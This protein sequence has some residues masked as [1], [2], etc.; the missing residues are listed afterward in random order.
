MLCAFLGIPPLAH[1]L[2]GAW[3]SPAGWGL[4]ALAIPMVLIADTA[5]KTIRTKRTRGR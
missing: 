4:A 2:G 1:A 3:P 5:H